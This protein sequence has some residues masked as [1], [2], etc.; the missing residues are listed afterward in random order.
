MVPGGTSVGG[1]FRPVGAIGQT[2]LRRGAG[3]WAAHSPPAVFLSEDK[4]ER[5]DFETLVQ[6][7]RLK[8]EL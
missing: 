1:R 2:A 4:C 7:R 5:A 8:A 6:A 3:S